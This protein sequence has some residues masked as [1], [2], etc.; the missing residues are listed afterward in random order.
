M[1]PKKEIAVEYDDKNF[2]RPSANWKNAC[3]TG[4]AHHSPRRTWPCFCLPGRRKT[5]QRPRA[6]NASLSKV[7][8]DGG[9]RMPVAA[10]SVG[11]IPGN[12]CTW[13]GSAAEMPWTVSG[14]GPQAAIIRHEVL[15]AVSSLAQ[16]HQD[17]AALASA[18]LPPLDLSRKTDLEKV[19]RTGG[20]PSEIP[21]KPHREV[22]AAVPGAGVF[23]SP[24]TECS[25]S[26]G[27]IRGHSVPV[28]W[29]WRA[30]P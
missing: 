26:D 15:S 30:R 16:R 8:V 12:T 6:L 23:I 27:D 7:G 13:S 21:G 4:R 25:P 2:R 3:W 17:M 19:L 5:N 18:E 24:A 14:P 20:H 11:V 29:P 22:Q 28:S 1:K 9:I 10:A